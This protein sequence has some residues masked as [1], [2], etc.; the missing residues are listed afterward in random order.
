MP[1][2]RPKETTMQEDVE[3]VKRGL[4]FLGGAVAAFAISYNFP[5][6]E[7][8]SY[9][10]GIKAINRIAERLNVLK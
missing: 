4:T 3:T 10:E 6:C 7:Y 9:E 5:D 2:E 8:V 1:S